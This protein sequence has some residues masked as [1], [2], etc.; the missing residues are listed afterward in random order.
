ERRGRVDE[1]ARTATAVE[2]AACEAEAL[3]AR[4]LGA[5]VPRGL[6]DLIL[7]LFPSVKAARWEASRRIM[8]AAGESHG[9]FALIAVPAFES[10]RIHLASRSEAARTLAR[11]ARA[12]ADQAKAADD[13][14]D[15]EAQAALA[16]FRLALE[17]W[18]KAEVAW[19]GHAQTLAELGSAVLS[20]L[21]ARRLIDEPVL[22]E[23]ILDVTWR[24][25]LF[26]L[27]TH[28]WEARW[29]LSVEELTRGSEEP[30]RRLSRKRRDDA[31]FR[32]RHLAQLTPC[33][34]STLFMLPEHLRC[35]EPGAPDDAKNPPLF[36]AVDLL[37][38]DEAGQVSPEVGAL[39]LALAK[40][41]LV[42]GDVH[43]IEP[44]WSIGPDSD[45]GNVV[46]HG[47]AEA[48]DALELAGALARNGSL[49]QLARGA[50][51]FTRPDEKGMFLDEHRRCQAAMVKVCNDLVYRGRLKPCS[52]PLDDPLLPVLGWAQLR[53]PSGRMGSS[54]FNTGEAEAIA[55]WLGRRRRAIEAHYG[56]P[57]ER[58]VGV[59]TPFGAQSGVL[60]AAAGRHGIGEDMT[61][62]TVHALQGAEREI[63]LFSPTHTAE[64][65]PNPFFDRGPNMLNVAVSRAKHS[66]LVFGDMR[67]FDPKR[68]QP[69]G[70][71][72]RHLFGSDGVEIH[73]VVSRPQ[74]MGDDLAADTVRVETLRQHR[75][76]LR[77]A[78]EVARRRVLVVSPYLRVSAVRDDGVDE[79]VR[80]ATRRGATVTVVYDPEQNVDRA[81]VMAA[82]TQAVRLLTESGAELRAVDR[83]HHK[84]LAVDDAWI[85][86]GSFNWLSAARDE[87]ASYAR[88]ERTLQYRG[89]RAADFIDAAWA[90]VAGG[91][92]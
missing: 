18:R 69:S 58:L 5:L 65:G 32:L 13:A 34:V 80:L 86:E 76:L 15:R 44:V 12:K 56:R 37:I 17:R 10:V 40:R 57:L 91:A 41:A 2:A 43:Q 33:F 11:Q 22:A 81:G 83:I 85:A 48:E 60:R 77:A 36:D 20:D 53:A 61:V 31:V 1:L 45:R 89:S 84:T 50:T 28:Y 66:F 74:F 30:L 52:K 87:T 42:V 23:R 49:M 64:D 51:A 90:E 26:R 70:K 3:A 19:R 68:N 46:K 73:D 27:A 25:D 88:L 16:E 9:P 82:T 29:L 78:F 6:R 35:F 47:L 92:T 67:I 4:A 62:G 14:A 59:V 63:V 8:A 71:L 79:L 21:D 38:V 55:E 24:Y 54:R 72:A 39:P 75:D 7:G